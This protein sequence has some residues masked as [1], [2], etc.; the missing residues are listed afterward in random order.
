MLKKIQGFSK[1]LLDEVLQTKDKVKI[2]EFLDEY[3]LEV[4]NKKIVPKDEYKGLWKQSTNYWDKQ[5]LVTKI[6]LNSALTN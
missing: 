6:S 3:G 2:T 4:V 1:K 5:Q